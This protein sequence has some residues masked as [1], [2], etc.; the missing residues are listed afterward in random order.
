[1]KGRVDQVIEALGNKR[2]RQEKVLEFK[3]SV[4]SNKALKDYFKSNPSE[5]EILQNDIQK[6]QFNDKLLFK[7]LDTLPFYCIPTKIIASTEEDLKLCAAGTG[8]AVP[9]WMQKTG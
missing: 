9:E 6:N 3:K 1:M 8:F 7:H 2:V 5:K 4:V